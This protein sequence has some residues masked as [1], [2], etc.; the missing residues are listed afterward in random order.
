MLS[1]LHNSEM[2]SLNGLSPSM[3]IKALE[4]KPN[5]L[6]ELDIPIPAQYVTLEQ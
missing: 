2:H 1:H 4:A 5:F 6:Q 3:R